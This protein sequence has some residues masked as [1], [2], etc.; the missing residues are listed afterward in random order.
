VDLKDGGVDVV[1][2]RPFRDGRAGFAVLQCQCTVRANW[3]SKDDDVVI[4]KWR[5][6]IDFGKDP[7][8]ALAIPFAVDA[9]FDQWDEV[10]R[11]VHVLLDRMRLCE[12]ITPVRVPDLDRIATWVEAER[13][14]NVAYVER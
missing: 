5:G 8:I 4:E 2:W 1:C 11:S 14:R 3:W 12:L 7:I 6:R 10:R 13:G 9:A